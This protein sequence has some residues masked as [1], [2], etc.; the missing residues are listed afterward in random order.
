MGD[1]HDRLAQRPLDAEQLV[2]ETLPGDRVDGTERLVHEYDGRVG[3]EAPGHADPLLLAA[4]QLA[5]VTVA[6]ARRVEVDHV[7]QLVDPGR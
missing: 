5:R 4:G 6:V 7:E 3:R 1:A 2:L